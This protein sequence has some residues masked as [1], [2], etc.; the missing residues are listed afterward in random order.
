MPDTQTQ[1]A[2]GA[3][4]TLP[5]PELAPGALAPLLTRH[6]GLAGDLSPL[7]SERDLNHRLTTPQ[8]RF[9]VKLANPA[10]PEPM[11]G[12]QTGA[13][14]HVAARD[15]ALP[16][17]RLVPTRDG[18]PWVA[19]P[20]GRLRLLTWL[21]GA[22]L[23][24]APHGPAQRRAVGDALARLTAALA[25]YA[26]PADDHI[27]LWDIKQVPR[28]APLLPSLADSDLRAEAAA[29][30][31]DFETRISPALSRLPA[32]VCHADFN[33][34]N[35]LVAPDDP[36][37]VT[38]ILDFGDMVRTPRICDLA[39]A[40]AYQIDPDQAL[41]SLSAF[42]SGYAAR[43]PLTGPEVALLFDLITARMVTTLTIA[44]WRAAR[45][46][47]N[48]PYILRNAP[49]ARAGLAAFR[50]IDRAAATAA[51]A[52]ATGLE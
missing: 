36:T 33:P 22:P 44:N 5:P 34:H 4:L 45:Y 25:D 29:F 47:E 27:L 14:L 40:A 13:L 52:R 30:V 20:Q 46:P 32:Q 7:T 41:E 39:T 2:L 10:E 23:H 48:A 31:A 26:H 1:D 35:L 6:W 18:A 51:F 11:T 50:R 24:A 28:L 15:P 16:V 21:E 42:L 9:M 3:L 49:S 37:R 8:G 17:P 19:L 12:F 38:G 43:L